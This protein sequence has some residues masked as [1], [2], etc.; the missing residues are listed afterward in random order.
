MNTD[1]GSQWYNRIA[2]DISGYQITLGKQGSRRYQLDKLLR[3]AKRVDDFSGICAECQGYQQEITRMVQELSLIVQMP[4]KEVTKKHQRSISGFIE[5]LK[6]VHR[7]VDKGH[8]TGMGVG[9]GLAVGG[10]IGAALGAVADNPG[11]GTGIGIAL[12]MAVGA[13]LDRK[14]KAEDKVI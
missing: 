8:Y 10:G 1:V 7:L 6:K 5:H 9:I 14:A 4:E 13:F 2:S 12:G 3:I 11:I